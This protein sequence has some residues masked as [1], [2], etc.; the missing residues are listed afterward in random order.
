MVSITYNIDT[1]KMNSIIYIYIYS[2]IEM[3]SKFIFLYI[4]IYITGNINNLGN[5]NNS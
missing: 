1:K 5:D 3:L 2:I 4:Y